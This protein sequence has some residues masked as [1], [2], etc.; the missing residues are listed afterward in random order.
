[1]KQLRPEQGRP[2]RPTYP[3][4]PPAPAPVD[5]AR[6]GLESQES[7]P[8][9]LRAGA[10]I[11]AG[12]VAFCVP[13]ISVSFAA[14]HAEALQLLIVPAAAALAG[15][16][17]TMAGALQRRPRGWLLPFLVGL[18]CN[19]LIVLGAGVVGWVVMSFAWSF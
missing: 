12:S 9:P 15:L 1:M 17:V 8:F 18:A 10:W 13:V 6:P 7:I 11:G 5:Y 19:G 4:P 14:G 16:P 2:L 3:S